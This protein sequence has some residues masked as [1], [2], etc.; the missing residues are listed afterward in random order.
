MQNDDALYGVEI[1][2][3]ECANILHGTRHHSIQN[4]EY[5]NTYT[6]DKDINIETILCSIPEIIPINQS[7]VLRMVVLKTA[8]K[9]KIDVISPQ[10]PP[11]IPH[12]FWLKKKEKKRK[13]KEK[14]K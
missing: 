3:I 12:P 6:A 8:R 5:P 1:A 10:H 13:G 4:T 11:V 2:S 14:E 7:V 9:V